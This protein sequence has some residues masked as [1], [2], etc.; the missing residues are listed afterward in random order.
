[1][2]CITIICNA[3][4]VALHIKTI[5]I[6]IKFFFK[7]FEFRKTTALSLEYSNDDTDTGFSADESSI[8]DKLG[9]FEAL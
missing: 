3:N 6:Y 8:Q 5:S 1:M 4:L 9:T 7:W 2:H